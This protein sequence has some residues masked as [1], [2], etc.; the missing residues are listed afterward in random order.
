MKNTHNGSSENNNP[1]TVAGSSEVRR[2]SKNAEMRANAPQPD[3]RET[4][5]KLKNCIIATFHEIMKLDASYGLK[6]RGTILDLMELTHLAWESDNFFDRHGRLL[7]FN[8]MAAHVCRVMH[9]NVVRNPYTSVERARQRKGVR[10]LPI[11]D[12]YTDLA[13]EYRLKNPMMLE[14]SSVIK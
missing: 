13:I 6:W 8:V 1:K 5:R 3:R 2:L 12:R 14:V 7:A 11:L 10:A 4:R 9:C